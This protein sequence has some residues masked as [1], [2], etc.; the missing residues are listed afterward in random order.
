[1]EKKTIFRLSLVLSSVGLIGLAATGLLYAWRV[2]WDY[3]GGHAFFLRMA[4]RMAGGLGLGVVSFFVGWRRWRKVWWLFP[5]I[6]CGLYLHARLFS[7]SW[8]CSAIWLPLGDLGWFNLRLLMPVALGFFGSWLFARTR[9]GRL[10]AMLVLVALAVI[11]G[12]AADAACFAARVAWE[13]A[14]G[15][16][17]ERPIRYMCRCEEVNWFYRDLVQPHVPA[18]SAKTE[19]ISPL[20]IAIGCFSVGAGIF[21][22]FLLITDDSE[23]IFVALQG[24]MV[25]S[26]G[27]ACAL[28]IFGLLPLKERL[29]YFCYD[30]SLAIPLGLA[31]GLVYSMARRS[32]FS[33]IS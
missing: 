25:L 12:R 6:Y 23:R 18:G 8:G 14:R 26:G 5:A 3:Y 9:I 4:I 33:N 30:G 15:M 27:V 19:P 13:R 7:S 17:A 16:R 29:A 32:I 2:P 22:L 1:M 31:I 20:P 11:G 24:A 28:A 21:L 10:P